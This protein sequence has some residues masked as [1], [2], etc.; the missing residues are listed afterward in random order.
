VVAMDRGQKICEGSCDYV[1]S[2]ECVIEAY[3]GEEEC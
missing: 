2:A 1:L 3:L